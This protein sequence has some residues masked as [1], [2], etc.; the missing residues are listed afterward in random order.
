MKAIRERSQKIK[1]RLIPIDPTGEQKV[2]PTG[3]FSVNCCPQ[4]FI[5]KSTCKLVLCPGCNDEQGWKADTNTHSNKRRRSRGNDNVARKTHLIIA[6]GERKSNCPNHIKEDLLNLRQETNK[7]YLKDNRK[8]K[9]E[10]KS[11]NIATHCF[12][13]GIRL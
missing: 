10:R 12:N 6:G 3:F 13:C 4:A 1:G 8:K 2:W 9:E 11:S 5:P 7:E